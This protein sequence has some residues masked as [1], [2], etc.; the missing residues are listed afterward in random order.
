MSSSPKYGWSLV[1][2]FKKRRIVYLSPCSG[3]F[4]ASFGLSHKAEVIVRGSN[5]SK[6]I[7]KLLDE[8]P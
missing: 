1:L 6:L 8:A 5:V 3:C 4:R 2:K 7:P